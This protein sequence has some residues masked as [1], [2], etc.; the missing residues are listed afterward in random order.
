MSTQKRHELR[1]E[2]GSTVVVLALPSTAR[3]VGNSVDVLT[4]V[5]AL[6]VVLLAALS[7]LVGPRIV[8]LVCARDT[9]AQCAAS[10]ASRHAQSGGARLHSARQLSIARD[11]CGGSTGA[12]SAH[13][14]SR[15]SA[16]S[17]D[18]SAPSSALNVVLRYRSAV[19]VPSS[20]GTAPTR[21]LCA[22]S[23][24]VSAPS[25]RHT[26]ASLHSAP[27]SALCD[28]SMCVRASGAAATSAGSGASRS[29]CA[30]RARANV[31]R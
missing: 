24:C 7:V 5:A 1:C 27:R 31:V 20:L 23:R 4:L 21:R 17:V 13:C 6:G 10:A 11:A 28:K 14:S 30:W 8:V 16:S 9:A 29:L 2:H 22:T 26:L 25:V 3:V 15:I 19:R 12:L 18:G